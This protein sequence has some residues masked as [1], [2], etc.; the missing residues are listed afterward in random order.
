[1]LLFF[2]LCLPILTLP[3]RQSALLFSLSSLKEQGGPAYTQR[4]KTA[5]AASCESTQ[6]LRRRLTKV[7][8]LSMGYD[9]PI[10]IGFNHT[11]C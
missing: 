4:P 10:A 8:L 2:M 1:M 9:P 5:P 11:S 6:R 7:A 3:E